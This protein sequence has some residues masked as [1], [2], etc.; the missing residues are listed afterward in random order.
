[1]EVDMAASEESADLLTMTE[2]VSAS[3]KIDMD[4]VR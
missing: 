4:F 3:A 1:M 2:L